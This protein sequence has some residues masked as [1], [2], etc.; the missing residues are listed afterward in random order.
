MFEKW[1]LSAHWEEEN[2]AEKEKRNDVHVAFFP[3]LDHTSVGGDAFCFFFFL[4]RRI[5]LEQWLLSLP[6]GLFL[7]LCH[8]KDPLICLWTKNFSFNVLEVKIRHFSVLG[9]FFSTFEEDFS[10]FVSRGSRRLLIVKRKSEE[11]MKTTLKTSV[12]TLIK[13]E[14]AVPLRTSDKSP[15]SNTLSVFLHSISF[16]FSF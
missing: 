9:R 15:N 16:C 7:Y 6:I 1:S 13:T 4:S 11:Q 10:V 2:R 14:R 5:D 3:L 12:R 8:A